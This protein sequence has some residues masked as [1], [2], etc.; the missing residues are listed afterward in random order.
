M[1]KRHDKLSFDWAV[2][3]FQDK[4][5]LMKN[6]VSTVDLGN[7][8]VYIV[9]K[10]VIYNSNPEKLLSFIRFVED[11]S[12]IWKGTSDDFMVWFERVRSECNQS[13]GLDIT[14]EVC[15]VDQFSQFLDSGHPI[16]VYQWEAYYILW[17]AA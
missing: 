5:Y 7:I 8:F 16:Q 13:Y 14:F 6:G 12:G 1:V 10:N 11:G 17:T 9:F 2:V 15:Q 3:N 4:W